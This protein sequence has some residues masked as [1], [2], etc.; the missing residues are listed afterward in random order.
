MVWD[1][2]TSC[3]HE[4]A[5]IAHLVVAHAQGKGLDIGCGT[6]KCWPEMI[7]V[8]SLKDYGGQRPNAVDVVSKGEDLSL[9]GDKTLDY[10]FS[11]HFLEH[12][13]D[14]KAC[15]TEWWNKLKVGG[16]LILYLPH[17]K[18]YPNIGQPGSNPDHKH[19]YMPDDIINTM[20]EIGSW[21]L[22]EN[23][24]RERDN[25][26]SFFQVFHKLENPI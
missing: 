1:I 3:G 10:I 16:N 9:F 11:S 13:V 4:S 25:E 22:L 20:K 2:S 14:Y 7:G 5:K 15:L 8:D 23:E 24:D 12:V 19:D 18:F 17:K 6:M 26:Y 21:E